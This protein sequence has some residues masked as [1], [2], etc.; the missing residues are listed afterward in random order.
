ML[1]LV[2]RVCF[3]AGAELGW[4]ATI[5][6]SAKKRKTRQR[7][8]GCFECTDGSVRLSWYGSSHECWQWRHSFGIC[9]EQCG[10]TVSIIFVQI[11]MCWCWCNMSMY[12]MIWRFWLPPLKLCWIF[13]Q[14]KSN[15]NYMQMINILV[16]KTQHKMKQ[17]M[18]LCCLWNENNHNLLQTNSLS[19]VLVHVDDS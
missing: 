12:N 13:L 8:A 4:T 1:F 16:L 18:T 6:T 7:P 3:F 10:R 2:Y 5:R 11:F 17:K 9:A 19:T 14:Y 15:R